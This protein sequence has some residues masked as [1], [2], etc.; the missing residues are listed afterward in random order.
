MINNINNNILKVKQICLIERGTGKCI[1]EQYDQIAFLSVE[2][3]VEV[4][5]VEDGWAVFGVN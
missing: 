5:E 1:F 2:E 4:E 3:E